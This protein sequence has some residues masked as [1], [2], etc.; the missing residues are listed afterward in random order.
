MRSTLSKRCSR[1]LGAS[2]PLLEFD[3]EEEI[4]DDLVFHGG[5]GT[6][7]EMRMFSEPDFLWAL[8][9]AGFSSAH[10]CIDRVPVFGIIWPMDWAVSIVART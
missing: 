10:A 8:S 7:L 3:G 2:I 5:D 6:A 1:N 4:F 9:E